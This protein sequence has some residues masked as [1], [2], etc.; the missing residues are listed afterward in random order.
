MKLGLDFGGVICQ[1]VGLRMSL[2]P[3]ALSRPMVDFA[4]D[5]LTVLRYFFKER[6]HI[7]SRCSEPSEPIIRTWL[8]NNNIFDF[9]N[10]E[11]LHFVRERKD[12]APIC[13]E[14]G[15]THFVDNRLEVLEHMT[16]V[17]NR[18]AL[19]PDYLL[20]GNQVPYPIIACRAWPLV[21]TSIL[22]T[23]PVE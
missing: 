1:E 8:Q 15:I 22:S 13:A 19:N 16:M 6:I 23:F 7:I 11:R 2:D 5:A 12:K 4:I 18:Y 21:V 9:V 3:Q 10:P 20:A 17:A 14:L